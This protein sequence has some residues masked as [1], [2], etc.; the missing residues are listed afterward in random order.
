MTS[1]EMHD[2]DEPAVSFTDFLIN[3]LTALTLGG[4]AWGVGYGLMAAAQ[5][6]METFGIVLPDS[7]LLLTAANAAF[8]GIPILM[9]LFTMWK[10]YSKV[11]E[12]E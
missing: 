2:S 3:A 6:G 7:P 5:F 4:V 11:T 9:G 12:M 8:I 10:T 1:G